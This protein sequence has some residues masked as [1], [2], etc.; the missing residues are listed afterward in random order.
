MQPEES[1]DQV[2]RLVQSSKLKGEEMVKKGGEILQ[3]GQEIVDLSTASQRVLQFA[4]QTDNGYRSIISAWNQ[5]NSQQ[6]VFLGYLHNQPTPQITTSGTAVIYTMSEYFS[7]QEFVQRQQPESQ[8]LVFEALGQLSEI[9]DKF[10]D[11]GLVQGLMVAFNLDMPVANKQSPLDMFNV[12][13]DTF[14]KP[15]GQVIAANTSLIP[16]RQCIIAMIENLLRRRPR[17][18]PAKNEHSKIVSILTQLAYDGITEGAIESL[19]SRWHAVGGVGGGVGL[20]DELSGAKDKAI[21]REVW[22]NM[23]RR[24]TLFIREF[25]QTI[26]LRKIR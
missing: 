26:D 13:W 15:V 24:A 11:R 17:Q 9:A 8:A 20:V 4:P 25:L 21:L 1:K 6:D 19:A 7:S 5:L 14:E 12:A 22:R 18:E 2:E 3:F 16:M 23:L 10:A